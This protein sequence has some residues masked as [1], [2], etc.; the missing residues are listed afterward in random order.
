MVECATMTPWLFLVM[1]E[2]RPP[3]DTHF[4]VAP[5]A[6]CLGA[7]VC[8]G[9]EHSPF[10]GTWVRQETSEQGKA[11]YRLLA[12]TQER[13]IEQVLCV[14]LD[15]TQIEGCLPEP[16]ALD[17]KT[18]KLLFGPQTA[19]ALALG[20]AVPESGLREDVQMGRGFAR[21]CPPG[22]PRSIEGVCG[23]SADGGMGRGPGGEACVMQILPS[24]VA[25]FTDG[26]PR[27]IAR[28]K[29]GNAAAREALLQTLLGDD[30][31]N[32]AR[33]WR[34]GLRMLLHAKSYCDWWQSRSKLAKVDPYFAAYSIY[35]TGT[36]CISANQGKTTYR[37]ELFV[38]LRARARILAR[39]H[40]IQDKSG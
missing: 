29:A 23:P 40:E 3:G 11:R 2:A 9:A 12:A 21:K 25:L 19:V 33:C 24:S 28:A 39:K 8:E 22:G 26:D 4:S 38:K 1:V 17:R 35:G 34:T 31:E 6:D 30:P 13:A 15:G 16:V 7:E 18:K 14:R 36:S 20:A 10:Y 5:V 37:Y 32:L 27:L